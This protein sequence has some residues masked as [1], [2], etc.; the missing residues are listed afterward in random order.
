MLNRKQ[1]RGQ[2]L[3]T[4]RE[5]RELTGRFY[6]DLDAIWSRRPDYGPEQ[7]TEIMIGFVF[8]FARRKL[9]DEAAHNLFAVFGPPPK[10][11]LQERRK[12]W[13]AMQ[14]GLAGKPNAKNG[15]YS[16]AAF[17]RAMAKENES[18]PQEAKLG[19]GT[20]NWEN[21]LRDLKRMLTQKKY[22][23][24]VDRGYARHIGTSSK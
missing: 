8:S 17:A 9:G 18:L 21:M 6:E 7:M 15:K 24:A 14:Y 1:Q 16:M 19:S 20:T 3:G 5:A 13:L 4:A 10:R 2:M 12:A 22:R 23:D 11:Q